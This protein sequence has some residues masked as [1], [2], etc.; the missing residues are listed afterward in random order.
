MMHALRVTWIL[1]VALAALPVIAASEASLLG[2]KSLAPAFERPAHNPWVIAADKSLES[3]TLSAP[4]GQPWDLRAARTLSLKAERTNTGGAIAQLRWIVHSRVGGMYLGPASALPLSASG[5]VA[6]NFAPDV[7]ELAPVGHQR[8]WDVLAA[9]EVTGLELRAECVAQVLSTGTALRITLFGA[10]LEQ[11]KAAAGPAQ[12]LDLRRQPARPGSRAAAVLCFRID[13]LPDDP[14]APDGPGDVRVKLPSGK[15]ALAFLDQDYVELNDGAAVRLAPIGLPRW[16]AYLPEWNGV[17]TLE[18]VSGTNTWKIA[19]AAIE[20]EAAS[21]TGTGTPPHLENPTPGRTN[22][23]PKALAHWRWDTPLEASAP[24]SET[25]WTGTGALWK[26]APGG[27]WLPLDPG[28]LRSF[29]QPQFDTSASS[30]PART[31]PHAVTPQNRT[32]WRP[33]PFWNETWGG[34]AGARRPDSALARRMDEQLEAAALEGSAR[35]L[36]ILDGNALERQ[37]VFNWASHPLRA[38]LR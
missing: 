1:T 15:Q 25:D 9:A 35:P 16:R 18:I 13:P 10:N 8:P 24:T 4:N 29:F 5:T 19:C 6:V 20:E 23:Q 2:T 3:L 11:A 7:G 21:R 38:Q 26:L 32:I 34:Y 12:V 37:G 22:R 28:A 31:A 36:A 14:Y 17:G 27:D 33:V 30:P